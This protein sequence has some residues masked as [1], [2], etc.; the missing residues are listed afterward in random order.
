MRSR[1][2]ELVTFLAFLAVAWTVGSAS[3]APEG[4]PPAAMSDTLPDTPRPRLAPIDKSVDEAAR[5]TEL[6]GII[7]AAIAEARKSDE[8]AE[9]AAE[10]IEAAN[11]VLSYQLEPVCSDHFLKIDH[12]DA[13]AALEAA[14]SSLARARSLLGEAGEAL[15]KIPADTPSP[16]RDESRRG[17]ARLEA[18]TSAMELF[19]A[20]GGS[21]EPGGDARQVIS[22]LAPIL[23]SSD[24]AVAGAASFW[25]ACVRSLDPDPHKAMERLELAVTEVPAES[26]R[27]G[28]FKRLLRCRLIASAQG[29]PAALALLAQ[30]EERIDDWF[31]NEPDRLD[32]M[33]TVGLLQLQILRSWH[34]RL[35]AP[36][37]TDERAWCVKESQRV[38]AQR[39]GGGDE[40]TV[41]RLVEAIPFPR[42]AEPEAPVPEDDNKPESPDQPTNPEKPD[43][44]DIPP[45]E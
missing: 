16:S 25:R 9:Q 34:D 5:L 39:F 35:D 1:R 29:E 10:L 45:P 40:E 22:K 24:L 23:E 26:Q 12:P 6:A 17:I 28:F 20:A 32:A 33:R 8:P 42:P 30:V 37:Q 41:L 15:A 21:A 19:L 43:K 4:E 38:I 2:S 13:A 11:R 36:T 14:R 31:H 18:F 3:A 27:Y 44:P 7:D